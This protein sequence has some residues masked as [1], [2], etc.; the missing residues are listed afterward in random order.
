M[1]GMMV[2][3]QLTTNHLKTPPTSES[4]SVRVLMCVCLCVLKFFL[5]SDFLKKSCFFL[6]KL[7]VQSIPL[8]AYLYFVCCCCCFFPVSFSC[9]D[10][11]F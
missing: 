1:G 9:I 8:F 3:G 5:P 11:E 2:I 7:Y 4:M 6:L 10:F